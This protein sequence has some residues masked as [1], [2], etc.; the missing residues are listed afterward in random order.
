MLVTLRILGRIQ[1]REGC[2]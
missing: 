2:I 1:R